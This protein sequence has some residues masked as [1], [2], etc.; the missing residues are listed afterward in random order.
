MSGLATGAEAGRFSVYLRGGVETA[1][2]LFISAQ[3][4]STAFNGLLSTRGDIPVPGDVLETGSFEALSCSELSVTTKN[5][6]SVT[7]LSYEVQGTTTLVLAGSLSS[8]NYVISGETVID[9]YGSRYG[10]GTLEGTAQIEGIPV[11]LVA[12]F[13]KNHHATLRVYGTGLVT[14]GSSPIPAF[15]SLW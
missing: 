14:E 9:D 7:G 2:W 8:S 10:V 5:F 13:L 3:P 6:S 4:L 12:F 15:A 1:H 11:A